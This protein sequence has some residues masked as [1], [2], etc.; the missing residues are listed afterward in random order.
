[1][2]HYSFMETFMKKFVTLLILIDTL[3][4][5]QSIQLEDALDYALKNNPK[6]KQYEAKLNQKEYQNLEALGNFFPQI[7][8]NYSYTHL[9]DP[10][11][12][13]LDPIRQAMI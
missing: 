3:A 10:I 1:M 5:G 12:I 9:N 13:D 11:G 2:N 8:F 6:I 4:F 7:N